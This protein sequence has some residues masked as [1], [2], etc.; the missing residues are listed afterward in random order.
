VTQLPAVSL[1][2][3]AGH[4]DV[5]LRFAQPSLQPMWALD[6]VQLLDREN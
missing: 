6:S 5:C 1:E 4:H 2:R 3:A